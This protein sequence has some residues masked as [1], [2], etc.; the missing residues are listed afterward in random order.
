MEIDV[1]DYYLVTIFSN[2]AINSHLSI[3]YEM[4]YKSIA[5]YKAC[6]HTKKNESI[7]L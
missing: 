6:K 5:I 2:D 1:S 4:Y 3:I 7:G